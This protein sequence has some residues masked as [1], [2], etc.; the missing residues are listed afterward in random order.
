MTSRRHYDVRKR[1]YANLRAAGIGSQA[2]Q[3]VIKKVCDAYT[4]L[5]VNIRAG[6]LGEPGS[7]RRVRAESA[8]EDLTGIRARVRLRK[9]QRSSLHSWAFAQL[10]RLIGAR[11]PIS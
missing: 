7:S 5:K 3:H 9:D 10:G 8:L 4:T 11:G 1:T 2:A 6:N